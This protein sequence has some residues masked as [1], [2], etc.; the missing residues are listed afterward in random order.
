MWW[1][2][3]FQL[4]SLKLKQFYKL[5][6]NSCS[7]IWKTNSHCFIVHLFEDA[8]KNVFNSLQL[9]FYNSMNINWQRVTLNSVFQKNNYFIAKRI[10]FHISYF[11][12]IWYV[13]YKDEHFWYIFEE[14]WWFFYYNKNTHFNRLCYRILIKK[15]WQCYVL[16]ITINCYSPYKSNSVYYIH[17]YFS[18]YSAIYIQKHKILY[19]KLEICKIQWECAVKFLYEY[20]HPINV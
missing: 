16:N 18:K 9:L 1:E 15:Y 19:T 8:R 5:N 12:I 3:I 10:H 13:L 11:F 7:S 17:R 2:R 14:V 4:N 6:W 20:K